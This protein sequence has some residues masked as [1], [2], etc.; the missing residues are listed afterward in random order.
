MSVR[1]LFIL[2]Y[3]APF[4]M[5]Y[6]I[7]N[8][9]Y[10]PWRKANT[11][12]EE[13]ITDDIPVIVSK[14]S[15]YVRQTKF[16]GSYN[17]SMFTSHE[18]L[19][20]QPAESDSEL[21]Y[22]TAVLRTGRRIATFVGVS[23]TPSEGGSLRTFATYKLLQQQ[24][25]KKRNRRRRKKKRRSKRSVFGRDDRTYIPINNRFGLKEP[26][27]FT[28]R[29]ST[30]CTGILISP[31]HVLTA[32]HCVHDQKDYVKESKDLKIG[33][34]KEKGDLE[35]LGVKNIKLSQGWLQGGNNN[36]PFYDYALLK[37]DRK[38][39]RPYIKLSVSEEDHHGSGER[40]SFSGF[41]DDKPTGTM[42][43]R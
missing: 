11:F 8:K 24:Q 9:I 39:S 28:V 33:F 15:R 10:Y 5:G 37:L 40:I 12:L 19:A 6:D 43:Y 13:E 29:L 7:F 27:I 3:F 41:D 32:A 34:L 20:K 42:W 36:G 16:T 38:H 26:Y 4:V 17:G 21:S 1:S 18:I 30:G 22:E 35:W 23:K 31:R 25:K 14:Y 2:L